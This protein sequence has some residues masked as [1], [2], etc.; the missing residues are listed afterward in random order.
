[1]GELFIGEYGISE[2]AT[3]QTIAIDP[4]CQHKGI[5]EQLI[6]EFIDHLMALGVRKINT[7]VNSNDPKLM[8]F[9]TANR[10]V[11]SKTINLERSL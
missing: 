9:F 4:D 11:P 7:L 8:H 2:E 1:M 5:G 10:F 3:L 6:K